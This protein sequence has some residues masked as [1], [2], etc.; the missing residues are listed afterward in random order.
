MKRT[1]AV[2]RSRGMTLIEV[3][4]SFAVLGMIIISVWSSFDGTLKGIE[5]TE[6]MQQ[7]Y[8]IVRNGVARMTSELS[9]AYL[10]KNRPLDDT[11]H[12]TMFEGRD[13]FDTDSL[14]FS[15]FS[16]LRVRKDANESDQTVLQY[17]IEKDPED[18]S[19][20][21]LYRREARRLTGDLPED[22]EEFW[23]AYIAIED[24]V[25]FD[26]K[27]WDVLKEEWVDEWRTTKV[28]MH[29]DRL[30]TRVRITLG[31]RDFDGE[32]VTFT[33]QSVVMMQEA[34][35]LGQVAGSR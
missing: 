9:M 15:A 23:P 30:P 1:R 35:D 24:A 14:T 26:V 27:Y 29:P 32:I 7:R 6:R 19:R 12:F 34:I 20:T 3:M 33:A 5:I 10:S 28:D 8:S 18:G 2:A 13:N 16:H 31:V 21:H 11:R 17:F 25:T 4:I 22:M